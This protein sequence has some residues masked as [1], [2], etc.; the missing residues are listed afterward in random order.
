MGFFKNKEENI[1]TYPNIDK[2]G[3]SFK[4]LDARRVYL[5]FWWMLHLSP[6]AFL[7]IGAIEFTQGIIFISILSVLLGY[8]RHYI[9]T[10][11]KYVQI[12]ILAWITFFTINL[13]DT[14]ILSR[15]YVKSKSESKYFS[16][17]NAEKLEG[18]EC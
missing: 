9:I 13:I 14:L 17:F 4:S 12:Y 6:V 15:I 7:L 18:A 8:Y 10:R 3:L 5:G 1:V 11:R 2:H 16:E